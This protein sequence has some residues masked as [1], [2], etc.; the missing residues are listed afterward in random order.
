[1]KTIFAWASTKQEQ[2]VI[3]IKHRSPDDGALP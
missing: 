3:H 1:M 2:F